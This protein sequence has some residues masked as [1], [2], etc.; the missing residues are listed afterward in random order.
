[1]TPPYINRVLVTHLQQAEQVLNLA[2]SIQV[3]SIQIHGLVNDH[4]AKEIT[5]NWTGTVAR[6]YHIGQT[7]NID[8]LLEITETCNVIH[9]DTRTEDRLGGTGKTHDWKI[10]REVVIRLTE[11]SFP[12]ILA[13]GLNPSNIQQAI[14]TVQP[15]AVDVNSGVDDPCGNKDFNKLK[16]F[17]SLAKSANKKPE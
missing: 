17:I 15:Y 9:L 6:V 1:M 4:Q 16:Q 2:E 5:D 10:S 12:V 3:D 14:G 11:Y 8:R 7:T 13:G